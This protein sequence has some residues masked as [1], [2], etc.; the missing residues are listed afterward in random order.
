MEKKY[1]NHIPYS[2]E[3]KAL[4]G[5]LP[6]K[7]T[8][9][10]LFRMLMQ[11]DE[12]TLCALIASLLHMRE[13]EILDIL[14][15]NPIEPGMIIDDKEFHLDVRLI[16]NQEKEIDLEMQ[17]LKKPG[18]TDRSM[19][20]ACRTFDSLSRGEDY[21]KTGSM[22][23]ISLTDFTLFPESPAFL[24]SYKVMRQKPPHQVYTDKFEILN[25][26]LTKI[27]L[28]EDEDKEYKADQWAK[29]F[30]AKTWEDVKMIAEENKEMEQ[31]ASSFWQI[32]ED[33]KIREQIRR[34]EANEHAYLREKELYE[35]E[36]S[37]IKAAL[38]EKEQYIRE[39]EEKLNK[40]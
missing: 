21:I 35:Q 7:F 39:L 13:T 37:Q 24:S 36:I 4:K 23:Q 30:K 28:A 32:T 5:D 33:E 26:N 31:T 38:Q 3:W 1:N 6:V 25:L 29:L 34:R 2:D 14:V 16:L 15:V 20:Y 27:D 19:L 18:W 11:A 22:I 9:D 12:K 10:Y 40:K 17:V 8:N